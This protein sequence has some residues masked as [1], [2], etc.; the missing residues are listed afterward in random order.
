MLIYMSMQKII[1]H[2]WFDKEAKEA[3]EYYVSIFPNSSVTNVS[4]LH[5]TPSGDSDIVSFNLLGYDFMAISAGPLFKLNP[6][7][8][9]M[10]NF[11]P[12]QDSQAKEHLDAL[13]GKLSEGGEVLMELG[14]YPFSPHYGWIKDKYGVSWQLILTDPTGE[15][16]PNIVPTLMFVGENAGKAEEATDYYISLFKSSKRGNIARYPA[17]M[18]PDKEGTIMFTDFML[19][20]QWF[21]AM[22]SAHEHQF[23]FNEGISLLVNSTDQSEIDFL[24]EKLSAV[25]EAEQCGWLKDKWGL[26]WQISPAELG[27][28]M[29]SGTPDQINR[30]TQ[31]FLQMKKFDI[32]K[33]REAYEGK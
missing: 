3:A 13:W 18:A 29:E 8:S 10:V 31:C 11:D 27:E 5:N 21:A 23:S 30:L 4:T 15:P 9:F 7:I 14:E 33:L 16:R 32:A 25:P 28:M 22:D 1:P 19:E 26:S 2:L 20:G 17:G 6:S 24:W 12:S